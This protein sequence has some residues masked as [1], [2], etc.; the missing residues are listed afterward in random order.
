M[1][2]AIPCPQLFAEELGLV[3]E[4]RLPDEDRVKSLLAGRGRP[5]PVPG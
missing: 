4:V 5:V 2:P 1:R 3:I